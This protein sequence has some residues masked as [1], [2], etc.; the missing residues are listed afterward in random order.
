MVF[1]AALN[2]CYFLVIFAEKGAKT[3]STYFLEQVL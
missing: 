2:I 1:G 3:K